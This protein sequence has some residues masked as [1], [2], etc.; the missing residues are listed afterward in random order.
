LLPDRD[1]ILDWISGDGR[2]A[3]VSG[4]AEVKLFVEPK[5]PIVRKGDYR[6]KIAYVVAASPSHAQTAAILQRAVD[7]IDWSIT[8]FPTLGEQ[9][10]FDLN[11]SRVGQGVD[12]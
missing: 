9:E 10:Q 8:P 11:S 5:T 6:D 2:A 3:A 12:L 4:V 1:G 7:L